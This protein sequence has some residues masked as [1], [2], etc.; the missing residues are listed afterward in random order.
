MEPVK[1]VTPAPGA[2]GAKEPLAQQVQHARHAFEGVRIGTPAGASVEAVK[3]WQGCIV[4]K[5]D[6]LIRDKSYLDN[7]TLSAATYKH[8]LQQ[9]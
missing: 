4:E 2:H 7:A 6:L 8:N 1:K 5:S 3:G 9:S